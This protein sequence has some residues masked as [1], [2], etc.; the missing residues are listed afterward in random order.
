MFDTKLTAD[1]EEMEHFRLFF[2][3]VMKNETLKMNASEGLK[4]IF[5]TEISNEVSSLEVK[6]SDYHMFHRFF[7]VPCRRSADVWHRMSWNLLKHHLHHLFHQ[8]RNPEAFSQVSSF[9]ILVTAVLY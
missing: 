9:I 1:H 3:E 6:I 4:Q 7:S 8:A 5:P 2:D